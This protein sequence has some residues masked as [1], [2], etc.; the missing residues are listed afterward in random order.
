M[1]EGR[2]DVLTRVVIVELSMATSLQTEWVKN[3]GCY[4][5]S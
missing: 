4:V 3:T 1:Y 2:G 5:I